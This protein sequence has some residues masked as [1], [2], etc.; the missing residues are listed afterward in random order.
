MN[1]KIKICGI[2]NHID[3]VFCEQTGVDA[4]GLVF[5]E[6]S[7]RNVSIEQAIS[8]VDDLPPF[9]TVVALFVNPDVSFVNQVLSKVKIDCLQFHGNETNDFC[10][11]FGR[12]WYKAIKAKPKADLTY[13]A[14]KYPD[15]TAILIDSFN[16]ELAG[17]TGEIFDWTQLPQSIDKP[18]ILAGGLKPDNVQQAISQAKPW[19]V[20]V[21]GGVEIKKGQKSQNLIR[22]FVTKV[23]GGVNLRL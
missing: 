9:L 4:I 7:P 8:I 15:S 16:P 10:Q 21:S 12:K 14:E 3:A 2:Q 1:P 5:Y 13:E 6:P 19:A 17:G 11:Q 18:L 22:D 23:K 20:D